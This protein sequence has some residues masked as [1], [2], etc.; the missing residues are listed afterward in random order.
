MEPF[1]ALIH[2][3]LAS[4]LSRNLKPFL[5]TP[6]PRLFPPRALVP[7]MSPAASVGNGRPEEEAL[8]GEDGADGQADTNRAKEDGL[9]QLDQQEGWGH[10]EKDNNKIKKVYR[11]GP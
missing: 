4:R 6:H 5:Q 8:L 10:T 11:W 1:S 2:K 3:F 9:G 7:S